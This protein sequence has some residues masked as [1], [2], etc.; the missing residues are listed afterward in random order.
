MLSD[1]GLLGGDKREI[2][3]GAEDAERGGDSESSVNLFSYS[4][5]ARGTIESAR[6]ILHTHLFRLLD[7]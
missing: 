6:S 1:L 5:K 4:R 7:R 3:P 2:L